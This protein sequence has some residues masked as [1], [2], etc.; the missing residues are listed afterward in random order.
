MVG[1]IYVAVD[2]PSWHNHFCHAPEAAIYRTAPLL[3]GLETRTAPVVT[4][5][6]S[7]L[8]SKSTE[9]SQKPGD[10]LIPGTQN[11]LDLVNS[12]LC[13]P[14]GIPSVCKARYLVTIYNDASAASA[15]RFIQTMDHTGVAS[16][17]MIV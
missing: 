13:G 8:E 15:V 1:K 2:Q 5:C 16:K 9:D 7:C 11:P 3:K 17:E 12:D 14:I 4:A 10:N 6:E